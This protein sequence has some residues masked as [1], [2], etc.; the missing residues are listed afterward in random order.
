MD[1][2]RTTIVPTRI[3]RKT[4]W[5]RFEELLS[6]SKSSFD[7]ANIGESAELVRA[8]DK[9]TAAILAAY[10]ACCPEQRREVRRLQNKEKVERAEFKRALTAY[11]KEVRRLKRKPFVRFTEE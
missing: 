7:V 9:L 6:D 4:N 8:A 3:P 1:A 10:E 11:S 2:D 5:K